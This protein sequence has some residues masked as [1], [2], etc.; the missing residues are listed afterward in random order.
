MFELRE[1]EER[2]EGAGFSTAGEAGD[3]DQ[4]H[5]FLFLDIHKMVQGYDFVARRGSG[6]VLG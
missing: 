5:G 6:C 3:V 2:L 4:L 1:R